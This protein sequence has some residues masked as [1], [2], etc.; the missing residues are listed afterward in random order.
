[1]F[2]VAWL[3]IMTGVVIVG[4]AAWFVF[5]VSMI[6]PFALPQLT[7]NHLSAI[8]AIVFIAMFISYVVYCILK[9]ANFLTRWFKSKVG[10]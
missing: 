3:V 7:T 9:L 6:V 2:Q 4:T 8:A 1:M 5:I 10:I